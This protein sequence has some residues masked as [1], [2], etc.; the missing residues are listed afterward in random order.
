[1]AV[2]AGVEVLAVAITGIFQHG[3]VNLADILNFQGDVHFLCG[4]LCTPGPEKRGRECDA[5][6]LHALAL[7]GHG[8][9]AA[10]ETAGQKSECLAHDI[11]SGLSCHL[12]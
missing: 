5:G 9:E 6:D 10:V 1:M 2:D 8:G 12:V 3:E 7:E 11:S 4:F